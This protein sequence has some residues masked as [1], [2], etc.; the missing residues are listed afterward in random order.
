MN[1]E[2]KLFPYFQ[3]IVCVASGYVIGYEALARQYNE[4]GQ[5]ISAGKL[6]SS[7]ELPA[8]QLIEWDRIIRR[9]ALQRFSRLNYSGYLNL[10]ISAAWI[11]YVS[12]IN[13]LPTIRMIDELN[14]DRDRIIIE[15]TESKGDLD[16]LTKVV[17]IYRKHGLKV[18]IDDFGAGFS[19]LER[20]M[21]IRPDIIKLDMQLFQ[22]AT[23]GGI[24]SDIVH[25]LTRLGKRTGCRVVCE[26]VE[27]DNEFL[28]GLNCGAQYMQ[29]YLF[30]PAEADF[31]D[32]TYY[33]GR[34]NLLR[35]RF[36]QKTLLKERDKIQY[37]GKVK[38]LIGL[39]QK[40][41]E[42]DFNLNELSA[43]PFEK[44]GVLRFYLCNNKGEQ[45][46][47]NF[48][49]AGGEWFE[50]PR[51]IGF[52]WSWRPYF[53]QLLALEDTQDCYRL[54][55][56]ERYRDFNTDLL[57]KTLALRLDGERI[58]LIDIMAEWT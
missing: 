3:P 8:E 4:M 40:A 12:D 17:R 9:Q 31:K 39:L 55:T 48:N 1:P 37:I 2:K 16:K 34:I 23:E 26:G 7:R 33:R 50:E 51:T 44:S 20:V 14:I 28:F 54:V 38:G 36:L 11:D 18:A 10:N 49:F 25:L 56:S 46:S 58:L 47:S 57:C 35:N 21:A 45:I 52:N 19:Q 43:H 32:S 13:S 22:K 24:A 29:G 53:Y 42:T 15:I 30:A 41:L 5:I 27:T 6:F